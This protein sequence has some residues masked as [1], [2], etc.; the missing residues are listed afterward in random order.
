VATLCDYKQENVDAVRA[1]T[2]DELDVNGAVIARRDDRVSI[3][4]L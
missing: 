4:N 2:P 3:A 1:L